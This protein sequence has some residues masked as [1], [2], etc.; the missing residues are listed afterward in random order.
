MMAAAD[1]GTEGMAGVQRTSRVPGTVVTADTTADTTADATADKPLYQDPVRHRYDLFERRLYDYL[2]N[3]GADQIHNLRTSIRRLEAT[4]DA[5]PNSAKTARTRRFISRTKSLF[6]G[7]GRLR[8]ADV[9]SAMLIKLGVRDDSA[10][11]LN[12]RSG[13]AAGLDATLA[14]A[15]QL[16]LSGI[17]HPVRVDRHKVAAKRKRVIWS[18]FDDVR[19]ESRIV[20]SDESDVG[21]LHSMRKTVKRLRYLLE[22]EERHMGTGHISAALDSVRQVQESAGAIHDHDIAIQYVTCNYFHFENPEKLFHTLQKRRHRLYG[23]LVGHSV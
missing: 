12:L 9:I 14:D 18:L 13:K 17:P 22:D 19:R 20:A 15:R 21:S 1:V 4:Y 3:P 11:V 16:A 23:D 8:D 6:K 7:N 10:P 2:A 5:L